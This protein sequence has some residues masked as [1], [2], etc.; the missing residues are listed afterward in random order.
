ML[1]FIHPFMQD[2]KLSAGMFADDLA[3]WIAGCLLPPF[4]N[5]QSNLNEQIVL[6][7]GD[8]NKGLSKK[9]GKCGLFCL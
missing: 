7:N 8:H 9:K 4:E 2:W 5:N 3:A 6:L 1:R